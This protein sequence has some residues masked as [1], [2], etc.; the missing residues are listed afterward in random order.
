MKVFARLY[1]LKS[2][3]AASDCEMKKVCVC[4]RA[5]LCVCGF[6]KSLRS[7]TKWRP[8]YITGNFL[9]CLSVFSITHTNDFRNLTFLSSSPNAKNHAGSSPIPS[10]QKPPPNFSQGG[11]PALALAPRRGLQPVPCVFLEANLPWCGEGQDDQRAEQGQGEA[12]IG[13]PGLRGRRGARQEEVPHCG[14]G[15][16]ERQ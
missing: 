6:R 14:E 12:L 11:D 3:C 7:L 15:G 4:L 8:C 10:G 5:C 13:V 1:F 9:F 2:I 16:K